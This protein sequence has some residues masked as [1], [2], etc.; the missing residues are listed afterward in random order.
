MAEP[1][2]TRPRAVS[3]TPFEQH[4]ASVDGLRLRYIDV[5]PVDT[6]LGVDPVAGTAAALPIVI[7]AGHTSRLEG[8]DPLVAAL[9]ARHRVIVLDFPGSGYS[10]KPEREY[11]LDFYERTLLAFLDQLG[12]D[13]AALIGGSL[14][15]NLT[16]RLGHDHPERFPRLAVWGPAGAWK[17]QPRLAKVV[18]L[19]GSKVLFW[20]TVWGQSRFW[21]SRDFPGRQA[22]LDGTF[23]YYREVMCRGFLQMYFGIAADQLAHSLF[24]IASQISQP[25]LLC[26]G[27]QDNGAGMKAGVARLHELIPDNRLR[28]FEGARHSLETEHPDELADEILQFLARPADD[29]RA[30]GPDR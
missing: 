28:V 27:D 16:L 17:A 8:F 12:V 13:C 7:L 5:R 23:A 10:D 9:R 29:A 30:T 14:G 24:D 25:T 4:D 3:T 2:L 26:W 20:P 6:A 18:R 15:G 19:T 21:Y 11:T 1:A 22:A